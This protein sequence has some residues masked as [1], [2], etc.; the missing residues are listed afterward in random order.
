[1]D[2]LA[3]DPAGAG[4]L[5]LKGRREAREFGRRAPLFVILL[6]G[7]LIAQANYAVGI[8][9]GR[10]QAQRDV[11]VARRDE[12]DDSEEARKTM[13]TGEPA[14]PRSCEALGQFQS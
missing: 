10:A 4:I 12:G 7:N 2:N 13:G 11:T 5:A 1:M 9:V 8:L 3:A 14:P 6:F